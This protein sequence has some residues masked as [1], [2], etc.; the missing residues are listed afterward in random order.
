[1]VQKPGDTGCEG[2]MLEAGIEW[3]L[4][5]VTSEVSILF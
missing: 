5:T 3:S 1:M 4:I 2:L